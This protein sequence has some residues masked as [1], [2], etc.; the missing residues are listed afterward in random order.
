MKKVIAVILTLIIALSASVM[1]FAAVTCDVCGGSFENQALLDAH[2]AQYHKPA[3]F[4][5]NQCNAKF[6]TEADLKDHI[7]KTHSALECP[8]CS[9]R[10][11]GSGGKT[12]EEVYNEH[13]EIHKTYSEKDQLWRFECANC[14]KRYLNP[15]QMVACEKSHIKDMDLQCPECGY[16]AQSIKD[17]NDHIKKLHGADSQYDNYFGEDTTIMDIMNQFI[18]WIESSKITD[19]L[20]EFAYKIFDLLMAGAPEPEVAGAMDNLEGAAN[21]LN[22]SLP[23]FSGLKDWINTIKQKIKSFYAGQAETTIEQTQA[24]APVDTGSASGSI[25]IFA[26][27]SVAATAAYVCSKKKA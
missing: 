7:A 17:Y 8:V 23:Q 2:K 4:K 19:M 5:C 15:E 20:L 12:A 22:L 9:F 6:D 11:V 24:E 25:A 10:C 14:H 21:K 3:E 13:L 27:I 26:T 18:A 16:K 1:A